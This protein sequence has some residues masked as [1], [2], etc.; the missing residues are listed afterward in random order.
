MKKRQ[1][2]DDSLDARTLPHNLEAERSV[3]GAVLVH[4]PVM[5]QLAGVL[6]ADDF[7]RD[8]HRR[9]YRAIQRIIDE[10]RAEADFVTLK[11]ELARAG[12]LDEVGGPAYVASLADGVPR[13]TN[14]R[15]YA[16][17]VKEKAMLRALIF[18]AN[19]VLLDAY[20]AEETPAVLVQQADKLLLDVQR[21]TLSHRLEDVRG[22][23][24]RIM[25][26]LEH[27]TRNRGELL[28]LATGFKSLDELT[29]GWQP[30]DLNII[31][32]RPSIGKTTF[33]LNTAI[34]ASQ[35]GKRVVIFSLEMRR[36]QLEYRLLSTLSNVPLTRML[37]GFLGSKDYEGISAGLELLAATNILIDDRSAQPVTSM[38]GASRRLRN[39]GGLDL[40]VIDYVQL[41]PGALDGK[42][43]RNEQVTDI[44]RRLKELADECNVPVL[45]VS[46]L[47][48][49]NEK[50]ADPRPRLSDLRE[51]GALEQDADAVI[52]LHRA[53]HRVGGETELIIEKQ[54]N[55]PTGT[56]MLSMDRDTTTF[57][58]AGLAPE[59]VQPAPKPVQ[60]GLPD[61][62]QRARRRRHF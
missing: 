13:A 50:R 38:R 51:S 16:S 6:T 9:I 34:A 18:A 60:E 4:N 56:V 42:A 28:G 36:K 48:R 62:P 31:A 1:P 55:G 33:V 53:N 19:K 41:V 12:D 3:L 35:A 59:P 32:A 29:L 40:I 22:A 14:V 46:Q 5:E 39:E 11:E 7:Y 17:I 24:P 37:T 43:S 8:A 25:A 2:A 10:R 23:V 27:R 52:F 54:R 30:G 15:H 21:A 61:M 44:S 58:D 47:S 20:A 57:T 49:A 45:L 26:D